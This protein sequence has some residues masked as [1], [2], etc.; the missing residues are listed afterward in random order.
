MARRVNTKQARPSSSAISASATAAGRRPSSE[1]ACLRKARRFAA[2]RSRNSIPN[3]SSVTAAAYRGY[4]CGI[5]PRVAGGFRREGPHL[6]TR[7]PISPLEAVLGGR[8]DVPTLGGDQASLPLP[9]NTQTGHVFRL[10]GRGL[11]L[12]AGRRGDMLV[13]VEVHLPEILDEDSKEMVRQLAARHPFNPR[14][15]KAEP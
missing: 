7:Q 12:P 3:F 15:R 9:P 2:T 5:D 13:R 6:Y 11:E 1:I 14:N 10:R 4:A 8:I